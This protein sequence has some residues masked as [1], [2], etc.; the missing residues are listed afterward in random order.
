MRACPYVLTR[1]AGGRIALRS[2]RIDRES[3][4][5]IRGQKVV[6]FRPVTA[7]E[8]FSHYRTSLLRLQDSNLRPGG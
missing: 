8:I 6:D 3:V 1:D 4:F 7:V 2:Q 5:E